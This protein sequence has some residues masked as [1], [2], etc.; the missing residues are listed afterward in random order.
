MIALLTVFGK[1]WLLGDYERNRQV[2]GSG[3]VAEYRHW[4]CVW[5][6]GG[7]K[8]VID[9]SKQIWGSGTQKK[10]SAGMEISLAVA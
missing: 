1:W 5:D 6:A 3:C 10:N 9:F 8:Y 4:G 2:F 7:T